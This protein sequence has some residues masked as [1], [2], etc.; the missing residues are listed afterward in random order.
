MG[1]TIRYLGDYYC[2]NDIYSY[3]S[4][5]LFFRPILRIEFDQENDP[6]TFAPAVSNTK[7]LTIRVY[8]FGNSTAHNCNGIVRVI[9]NTVYPSENFP[10]NRYKKLV[11]GS[12]P[13]LSDL[14]DTV[15]I[16][17]DN[18]DILH[19]VF[20]NSDFPLIQFPVPT[21]YASFS[22]K[23]RLLNNKLSIDILLQLVLF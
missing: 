19:V 18:W 1:R 15:D 22:K 20:A 2:D 21:R 7:Y 11:R 4:Q 14:K 13:D 5:T 3:D 17:K 12:E 8:N 10:S 23:D 16:Q 9:P 6:N